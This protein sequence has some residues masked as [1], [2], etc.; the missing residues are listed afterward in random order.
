MSIYKS[1]RKGTENE[2][3]R[4][5]AG[6]VSVW[7]TGICYLYTLLPAY[8]ILLVETLFTIAICCLSKSLHITQN[9]KYFYIFF[10]Q[11]Y[12]IFYNNLKHIRVTDRSIHIDSTKAKNLKYKSNL[13]EIKIL[14]IRI[15]H[16]TVIY[17]CLAMTNILH[18]FM[19]P[20]FFLTFIGFICE[21]KYRL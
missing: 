16:Q 18:I 3:N 9:V 7:N 11:K 13:V 5:K 12:S 17:L 10:Y 8:N 20:N 1:R 2:W 21:I 19:Q 6:T 4:C 14:M 15:S